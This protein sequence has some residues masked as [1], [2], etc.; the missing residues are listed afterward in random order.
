MVRSSFTVSFNGAFKFYSVFKWCFQVL[1][2]LLMV[3]SALKRDGIV[4]VLMRS[5]I[6]WSIIKWA[7]T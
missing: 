4:L 6:I 5:Y 1:Q 3:L 2:C 7:S